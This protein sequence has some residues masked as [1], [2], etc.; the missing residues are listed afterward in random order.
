MT[1]LQRL[2]H[3]IT[4]WRNFTYPSAPVLPPKP[5]HPDG[6]MAVRTIAQYRVPN[7]DAMIAHL[8]RT[9]R[10]AIH[11]GSTKPNVDGCVNGYPLN[12]GYVTDGQ[13]T[14]TKDF[15]AAGKLMVATGR[16]D[17][18]YG[19]K[20]RYRKSMC[21]QGEPMIGYSDS[22]LH[23]FDTVGRTITEVQNFR[24]SGSGYAC[25]GARQYSLDTPSTEVRGSSAAKLS[26][27]DHTLRYDDLI[28]NGWRQR[29]S[30]GVRAA[31]NTYIYPAQGSDGPVG[32]DP[33]VQTT[34]PS[35][36][37]D[38]AAPPMGVVLR[39]EQSAIER[40]QADGVTPAT[41]PQAFAVLECWSTYGVVIVDT[42]GHNATGLEP[43]SRWDQSDLSILQRLTMRDWSCWSLLPL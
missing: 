6:D 5:W 28:L 10:L 12:G 8:D 25:D 22:K 26:L 35:M 30:M 42:G 19:A 11:T 37:D 41:H 40:L 13:L 31:R 36:P 33:S 17:S 18:S 4:G 29:G 43:D 16:S 27:I 3:R 32:R 38:P 39:L 20:V 9:A 14:I 1:W 7:S 21:V 2:Q 15:P 24:Q 34:F 23:V